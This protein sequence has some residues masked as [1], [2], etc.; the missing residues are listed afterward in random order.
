MWMF[1]LW[2]T[3][4]LINLTTWPL[5]RPPFF[6]IKNEKLSMEK[7]PLFLDFRGHWKLVKKHLYFCFLGTSIG[8][9]SVWECRDRGNNVTF[10]PSCDTLISKCRP[11]IFEGESFLSIFHCLIFVPL[12]IGTQYVET[13]CTDG[14]IRTIKPYVPWN[15]S[16]TYW[17]IKMAL[18]ILHK[19]WLPQVVMMSR[20][21]SAGSNARPTSAG[22]DVSLDNE[23]PVL[24]PSIFGLQRERS[25]VGMYI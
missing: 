16:T 22:S 12:K 10:W 15:K 6:F 17:N 24:F 14:R 4:F 11:D 2:N 7:W 9:T 5:N 23:L 20:P 25:I 8:V 1:S 3:T 13:V 19:L 18:A 21:G